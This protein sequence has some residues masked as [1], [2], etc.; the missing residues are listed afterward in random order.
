MLGVKFFFQKFAVIHNLQ[1]LMCQFLFA[2]K[3]WRFG[4]TLWGLINCEWIVTLIQVSP[5]VV[6]GRSRTI[7]LVVSSYI[8]NFQHCKVEIC[9]KTLH[10]CFYTNSLWHSDKP[11][12]RALQGKIANMRKVLKLAT[13]DWQFWLDRFIS[14]IITYLLVF[15]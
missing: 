11:K 1:F 5:L 9:I 12:Y 8:V 4:E 10:C 7:P 15:N 14:C 3:Q 13:G 6:G 2:M